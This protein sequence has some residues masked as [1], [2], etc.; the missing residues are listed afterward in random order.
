MYAHH[1]LG[2]NKKT[3]SDKKIKKYRRTRNRL[4]S[5]VV[6]LRSE[7]KLAFLLSSCYS[8]PPSYNLL[9]R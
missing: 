1:Q 4:Y 8:M 7:E 5:T 2:L 3:V 9:E 6:V